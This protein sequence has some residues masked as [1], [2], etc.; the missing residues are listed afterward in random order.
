MYVCMYVC[1]YVRT[2]H[3]ILAENRFLA[4]SRGNTQLQMNKTSIKISCR[5]QKSCWAWRRESLF[6]PCLRALIENWVW[7]CVVP[8]GRYSTYG[9]G[10]SDDITKLAAII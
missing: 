1:M 10:G 2:C 9:C 8:I 3:I 7:Q 6:W 5:D 4:R